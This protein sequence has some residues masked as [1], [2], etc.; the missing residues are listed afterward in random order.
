M[1]VYFTHRVH[2]PLIDCKYVNL[3]W[4]PYYA[5]LAVVGV[6]KNDNN[7][8]TV[9]GGIVFFCHDEVTCTVLCVVYMCHGI[10]SWYLFSYASN[11]NYL[12]C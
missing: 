8:S 10:V 7:N 2:S 12:Y 5:L 11:K 1:S 3:S 6:K 9:G 4:H